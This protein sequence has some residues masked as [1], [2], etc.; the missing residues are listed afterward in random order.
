VANYDLRHSGIYRTNIL[1]D[2]KLAEGETLKLKE[3]SQ[4]IYLTTRN[5]KINIV[6]NN[7]TSNGIN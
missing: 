1:Q 5:I 3:E 4:Y 2:I 6:K 7:P